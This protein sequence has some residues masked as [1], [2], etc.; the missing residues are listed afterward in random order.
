MTVYHPVMNLSRDVFT[1]SYDVGMKRD[2]RTFGLWLANEI[3]KRDWQQSDLVERLGVKAGVVSSWINDKRKPSYE[4]CLAI[5][6][7]MGLDSQEVLARA[8]R[9]TTSQGDP[10]M[11]LLAEIGRSVVQLVNE[12]RNI[13]RG[14]QIRAV[15]DVFRVPV[16]NGMSATAL[17]SEVSQVEQWIEV[18]AS[19]LN[20][21]TRPAAYVIVGD[22]LWDRWGIKTGDTLIIDLANTDP[23][24]GQ[25]VAARIN[26][27]EETAKE[28]HRVANGVDLKP[29]TKGYSTIEVRAPDQ[30]LII[31]VYVT[32]LVTGKR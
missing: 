18:P 25:I 24:D 6:G 5:A 27:A 19:L 30:L 15:P 29:T 13:V 32:H 28:F 16:V 10:E 3:D 17:A 12:R 8:G 14:P 20:G 21:A 22:C 23:R 11:A 1:T 26:D 4:S 2:A 9:Q 7:A 31:G